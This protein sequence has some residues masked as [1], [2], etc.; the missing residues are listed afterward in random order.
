MRCERSTQSGRPSTRLLPRECGQSRERHPRLLSRAKRGISARRPQKIAC[1]PERDCP[2][3]EAAFERISPCERFRRCVISLAVAI[4]HAP[5]LLDS[6]V[7]ISEIRAREILDSRGNP[8]VE[9]DV[10]LSNG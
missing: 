5:Y 1:H 7:T 9:A 3:C 2:R 6:M 8:T 4:I 10:V